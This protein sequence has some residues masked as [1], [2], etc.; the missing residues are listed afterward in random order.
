MDAF[1]RPVETHRSASRPD[2][3][4]PVSLGPIER[5]Q[6]SWPGLSLKSGLPDFNLSNAELGY[7]RVPL[8]SRCIEAPF[9]SGSPGQ[10]R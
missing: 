10:A 3:L 9:R 1:G 2:S 8:P 7:S 5:F 6:P 4:H